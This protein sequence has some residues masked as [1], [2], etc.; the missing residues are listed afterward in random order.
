M[1]T[2]APLS[3]SQELLASTVAIV[4]DQCAPAD[5]VWEGS[6]RAGLHVKARRHGHAA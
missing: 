2:I 6:D 5:P 3:V 4:A 1:S